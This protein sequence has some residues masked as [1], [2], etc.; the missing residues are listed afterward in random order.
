MRLDT[1]FIWLLLPVFASCAKYN[2]ESNTPIFLDPSRGYGRIYVAEKVEPKACGEP[3][4]N[5]VYSKKTIPI[6]EMQGYVCLPADQVQY[7]LRYYNE[8][9]KQKAKCQ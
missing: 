5:F 7:N 8:Y 2:I 9:L 1:F 3:D 4:Y 6:S